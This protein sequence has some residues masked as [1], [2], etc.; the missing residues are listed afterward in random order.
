[1]A[2]TGHPMSMSMPN[3]A[4]SMLPNPFSSF[5]RQHRQADDKT[6]NL[7][8]HLETQPIDPQATSPFY[9]G[10]IPAEIRTLIFQYALTGS[11]APHA[12][13]FT[14]DP[15]VRYDHEPVPVLDD[16]LPISQP[17][18]K[19]SYLVTER[20]FHNDECRQVGE[21]FDWLRPDNTRPVVDHYNLLL[22]CRRVYL[23]TH[24]LPLQQ[25]EFVFYCIRGNDPDAAY[26]TG[27]P[28]SYL[29]QRLSRPAPGILPG[30]QPGEPRKQQRD[31]YPRQVRL[32]T[33]QY[34]L[35]DTHHYLQN[36][37]SWHR[38]PYFMADDAGMS[39]SKMWWAPLRHLRITLRRS[40]WWDWERNRALKISPYRRSV[41]DQAQMALDM[42]RTMAW[43]EM[44]AERRRKRA[45]GEVA[46]PDDSCAGVQEDQL[47]LFEPDSWGLAFREMTN[48]RTL[49]IDFETA[50]DK[51]GEMDK[52]VEWAVMWRFPLA[53][54][55]KPSELSTATAEGG[56]DAGDTGEQYKRY[57]C[58]GGRPVEKMSWRGNKAYWSMR[59]TTCPKGQREANAAC[60]GCRERQRLTDNGLGPRLYVWT[61]KWTAMRADE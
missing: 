21:G 1:M 3:R 35:E 36:S 52:I 15:H 59:C 42:G 40:D 39:N 17:F 12:K 6:F 19:T 55:H 32:L 18:R 48:L 44:M 4:M 8:E 29:A 30:G 57:L 2:G 14:H 43:S 16:L 38:Y 60:P 25:K 23:E 22:T 46:Q 33:Q 56:K 10:R 11:P 51:K 9:N 45:V 26:Y 5:S 34:W 37:T 53:P 20:G 41:R 28:Q 58:A 47:G 7:C 24:S 27:D 31:L 61:V 49:T 50:E 13:Q 54:G